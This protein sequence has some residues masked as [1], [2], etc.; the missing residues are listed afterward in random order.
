MSWIC[1]ECLKLRRKHGQDRH[2]LKA[3]HVVKHTSLYIAIP[4]QTSEIK[5]RGVV[6]PPRS[7]LYIKV[8]L[9]HV[10]T[11]HSL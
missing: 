4:K 9:N 10:M 2:K 1:N 5:F 3:E 11:A 6:L 7:L 8:S